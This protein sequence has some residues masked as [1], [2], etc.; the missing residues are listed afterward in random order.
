M[1]KQD[2]STNI[3]SRHFANTAVLVSV[4][5][6][7]KGERKKRL[8]LSANQNLPF[9][10]F[11]VNERTKYFIDKNFKFTIIISNMREREREREKERERNG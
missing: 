11:N 2:A 6:T 7:S 9:K 4:P 1:Y 10:F 3:F 8:F 5:D